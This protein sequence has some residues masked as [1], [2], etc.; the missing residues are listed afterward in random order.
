L[1]CLRLFFI[2]A[3]SQYWTR[4][5]RPNHSAPFSA[6]MAAAEDA[7]SVNRTNAKALRGPGEADSAEDIKLRRGRV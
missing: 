1:V 2:S 6:S 3:D 7:G 4:I 5:L